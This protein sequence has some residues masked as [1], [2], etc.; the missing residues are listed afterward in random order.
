[1]LYDGPQWVHINLNSGNAGGTALSMTIDAQN[2][3]FVKSKPGRSAVL[4]DFDNTGEC[5]AN[6]TNTGGTGGL[7]PVKVQLVNALPTY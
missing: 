6:T 4:M 7:G 2:V 3:Q 1:M 5:I